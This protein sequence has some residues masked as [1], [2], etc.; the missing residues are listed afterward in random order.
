MAMPF[1]FKMADAGVRIKYKG[2]KCIIPLKTIYSIYY[3]VCMSSARSR[4]PGCSVEHIIDYT[5]R[6]VFD[7]F[8]EIR[9]LGYDIMNWFKTILHAAGIQTPPPALSYGDGWFVVRAE[10]GDYHFHERWLV[11]PIKTGPPFI[12]R[13]KPK[14]STYHINDQTFKVIPDGNLVEMVWDNGQKTRVSADI[15]K[16]SIATMRFM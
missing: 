6:V 13:Y 7:G 5:Y 8:D 16:W 2:I 14:K 1:K 3:A 10:S 15:F 12:I 4:L 11:F 9:A